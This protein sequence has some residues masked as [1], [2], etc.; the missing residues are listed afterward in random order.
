MIQHINLSIESE[1]HS[2]AMPD[3]A[4]EASLSSSYQSWLVISKSSSVKKKFISG[5]K[6]YISAWLQALTN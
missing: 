6:K 5:L 1:N 2:R 4:L 3:V